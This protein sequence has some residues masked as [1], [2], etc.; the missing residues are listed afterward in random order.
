M[1]CM[2]H[3]IYSTLLLRAST[4]GGSYKSEPSTP[5]AP[6]KSMHTLQTSSTDCSLWQSSTPHPHDACAQTDNSK[7]ELV[8]YCTLHALPPRNGNPN[9]E[10]RK[11]SSGLTFHQAELAMLLAGCQGCRAAHCQQTAAGCTCIL[12]PDAMQLLAGHG[13]SSRP[14]PNQWRHHAHARTSK[15]SRTDM[16]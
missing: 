7:N 16:S 14:L 8:P 12:A 1:A 2:R 13:S 5:V 11:G 9:H 3:A 4:V 15:K 6:A 10:T